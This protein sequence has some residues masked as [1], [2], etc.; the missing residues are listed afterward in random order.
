M[1][2]SNVLPAPKIDGFDGHYLY[3]GGRSYFCA[4]VPY[5]ENAHQ[6]DIICFYINGIATGVCFPLGRLSRLGSHCTI[7]LSF[8]LFES[9]IGQ[10]CKLSYTVKSGSVLTP[11][12]SLRVTY[13]GET[14]PY[15]NALYDRCLVY[16][17]FGISSENIIHHRNYSGD[18]SDYGNEAVYDC[19]DVNANNTV[20]CSTISNYK[21]T[22]D[23]QT[24]LYVVIQGSNDTAGGVRIGS[25]V[26]LSMR[27]DS[28]GGPEDTFDPQI[29]EPYP[30]DPNTGQLVFPIPY[31]GLEQIYRNGYCKTSN[32]YSFG[33][34]QLKF[35][36][37]TSDGRTS[38]LWQGRIFTCGPGYTSPP[39]E[40]GDP[41]CPNIEGIH[42]HIVCPGCGF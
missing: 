16:S 26:S 22:P 28:C 12:E 36:Y 10:Q 32:G 34:G 7:K 1:Y 27:I 11:S 31:Y 25:E 39:F 5:Y 38:S 3:N 35:M 14:G 18:Y 30:D 37:S 19:D 9:Y 33:Y 13:T 4:I 2:Y 8:T 42:G 15:Q 17:S 41:E 29:M 24:G 40:E 21:N 6:S 20:T 23:G